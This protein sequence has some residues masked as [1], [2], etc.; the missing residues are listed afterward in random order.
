MTEAQRIAQKFG[1][2]LGRM[3]YSDTRRI[4]DHKSLPYY[5]AKEGRVIGQFA[6][7]AERAEWLEGYEML[8]SLPPI[9]E[10]KPQTR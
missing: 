5:I 1:M 10:P 9:P 8:R 2:T 6:T 7:T 3:L 4:V